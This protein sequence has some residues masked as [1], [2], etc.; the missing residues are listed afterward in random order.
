[1]VSLLRGS[2]LPRFLLLAIV[3]LLFSDALCHGIGKFHVNNRLR[4]EYDD[5]AWDDKD[6]T[7]SLKV[8]EEL[9]II[10]DID[11][12]TSYL[13]FVF[14]PAS[15]WW[16]G[17][18]GEIRPGVLS[19]FP[20]VE[21]E[22]GNTYTLSRN[23]KSFPEDAESSTY[24]PETGILNISGDFSM[25]LGP[26]VPSGVS[27]KLNWR[28]FDHLRLPL[29]T[30]KSDES[31]ER[32]ITGFANAE[33][34]RI[35]ASLSKD[36]T[37]QISGQLNGTISVTSENWLPSPTRLG[38]SLSVS[39]DGMVSLRAVGTD[40]FSQGISVLPFQSYWNEGDS[41]R[42]VEITGEVSRRQG[43]YVYNTFISAI[44]YL[45][46]TG[47]FGPSDNTG[48]EIE[49][50]GLSTSGPNGNSIA[51]GP[52][53]GNG[54]GQYFAKV[55][56]TDATG[57]DP[58]S[59]RGFIPDAQLK[60]E[61]PIPVAMGE[62]ISG[63]LQDGTFLL[64]GE[65][66]YED[67]KWDPDEELGSV[68]IGVSAND[69]KGNQTQSVVGNIKVGDPAIDAPISSEL[70]LSVEH[71]LLPEFVIGATV[72]LRDV[73]DI[74]E[75]RSFSPELES[76][77]L[78][79]GDPITIEPGVPKEV[80]WSI[81]INKGLKTDVS[82]NLTY[83]SE[84]GQ[85]RFSIRD[86]DGV[87]VS[88]EDGVLC[89]EGS[90]A[91]EPNSAAG[92]YT[93]GDISIADSFGNSRENGVLSNP[94]GEPV[95][96]ELQMTVMVNSEAGDSAN[97]FLT[98]VAISSSTLNLSEGG[99]IQQFTVTAGDLHSGV[100]LLGLQ[101][102]QLFEPFTYWYNQSAFWNN[103][104]SGDANQGAIKLNVN[105]PGGAEGLPSG[106]YGF[107]IYLTDNAGRTSVYGVPIMGVT[108]FGIPIPTGPSFF[109]VVNGAS[110]GLEDPVLVN[111]TGDFSGDLAVESGLIK[112]D[113]S[114]TGVDPAN[115]L[116]AIRIRNTSGS[117][118]NRYVF[119]PGNVVGQEG[120][121]TVF[122]FQL[123]INQFQEGGEWGAEMTLAGP[124]G[125]TIYSDHVRDNPLPE[126]FKLT[127]TNSLNMIDSSA[128]IALASVFNPNH[129][130]VGE[131]VEGSFDLYLFDDQGV[132]SG[133]YR[134][135]NSE[136]EE[137]ASG[138]F[139][140]PDGSDPT[141]FKQ[142]ISFVLGSPILG[143][144]QLRLQLFNV[145]DAAGNV[146]NFDSALSNPSGVFQ[147]FAFYSEILPAFTSIDY[148]NYNEVIAQ[149][150][151]FP[152]GT[153]VEDTLP[154]ADP[155]GD[156]QSNINE[157][158]TGTNPLVSNDLFRSFTE[159]IPGVGDEKDKVRIH[160]GPV[161]QKDVY[162]G[163]ER[164]NLKNGTSEMINVPAL[165]PSERHASIMDYYEV[166]RDGSD[167]ADIFR[168]SARARYKF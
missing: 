91:L 102:F 154:D 67:I 22:N 8:V 118:N 163:L 123:P 135:L 1:M 104:E 62:L 54:V 58:N 21:D 142:T 108:Q 138:L 63:R 45:D 111:L 64:L 96:E 126:G 56:V 69:V 17:E 124:G 30:L 28:F 44:S 48:P 39:G 86:E 33:R 82:Y 3:T 49:L 101:I 120:N 77:T 158:I 76:V 106:D 148:E 162:Y 65:F 166:T 87:L 10:Y 128:P 94:L 160:F 13:G 4:I 109:T 50:L 156:G 129:L 115:P 113:F 46:H 84:D 98:S 143:E 71:A 26:E 32:S 53:S 164:V 144:D 153:P 131:D 38:G 29:F 93:L 103:L 75:T 95:P 61:S 147:P 137:F 60:S 152:E 25:Y 59:I 110:G 136:F 150:E 146:S 105:L 31:F 43:D 47:E 141:A 42:E 122:N 125:I 117:F 27:L 51:F 139:G 36:I 155:D 133:S 167:D 99:G 72:T 16:E 68:T 134:I 81:K 85:S 78:N 74:L 100:N 19:G 52:R 37:Q 161:V 18:N 9:K 145:T 107:L 57:V 149:L 55:R 20:G 168:T 130:E 140:V 73:D 15:K 97:P 66:R 14:S 35:F 114:A 79:N 11:L 40:Q 157:L 5:N 24:D 159:Y 41:P 119:G 23:L 116:N 2:V 112:L 83:V 127:A 70:V 7:D 92:N 88:N 34:A 6:E 151:I 80:P 165:T 132:V 121:A 89:Y 90:V 12:D